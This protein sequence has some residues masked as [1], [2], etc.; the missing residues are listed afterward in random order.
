ML[1][2]TI[3]KGGFAEAL[4]AAR[5]LEKGFVPS[6]PVVDARYDLIVDDGMKLNRV[7]VKYCSSNQTF[8]NGS[9][10][11]D[12]R[13]NSRP[14]SLDEI[15]AL[16]VYIEQFQQMCWIPVEMIDGKTS[17]TIRYEPSKNGQSKNCIMA[18]DY[19]W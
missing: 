9:V 5:A 17:L 7:Q 12:L 16:V 3:A 13:R 2:D 8:A 19:I 10:C 6:K 11:V 18:E 14:Y 1:P 4:V 15:D